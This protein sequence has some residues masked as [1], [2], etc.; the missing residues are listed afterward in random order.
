MISKFFRL[1]FV[2]VSFTYA[3]PAVAE[4]LLN[5]KLEIGSAG[6]QRDLSILSIAELKA[7]SKE[8]KIAFLRSK[9]DES[10]KIALE[11]HQ[12]LN[13]EFSKKLLAKEQKLGLS[14]SEPISKLLTVE[15][16]V[17]RLVILNSAGD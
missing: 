15:E 14:H 8:E 12:L 5:Q 11:L 13:D 1:T 6:C 4:D 10:K 16:I 9:E 3:C 7:L 2:F 17:K